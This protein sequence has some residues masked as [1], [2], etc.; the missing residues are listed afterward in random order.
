MARDRS[1]FRGITRRRGGAENGA[2]S[3]TLGAPDENREGAEVVDALKRASGWLRRWKPARRRL[4]SHSSL[5]REEQRAPSRGSCS[6]PL[7]SAPPPL[8]VSLKTQPSREPSRSARTLRGSRL[9]RLLPV[10]R[11]CRHPPRGSGL[12]LSTTSRC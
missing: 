3:A 12:G 10:S 4:D 11:Y 5:H 9:P 1:W 8:R 7:R 6:S 2:R